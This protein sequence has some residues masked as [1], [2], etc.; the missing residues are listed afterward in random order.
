[1]LCRDALFL[2]AA[3]N[4]AFVV[5]SFASFLMKSSGELLID[6]ATDCFGQ[7]FYLA[8]PY[9]LTILIIHQLISKQ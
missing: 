3:W 5:R 6:T 1:V 7:N 2:F 8:R 9:A 4:N